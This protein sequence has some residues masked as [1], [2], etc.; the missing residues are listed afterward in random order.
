MRVLQGRGDWRPGFRIES[1]RRY[2]FIGDSSAYGFGVAPDQT[3][4]ASAE[5]QM[6]EL[7]PAWPVE[8]VN[9]GVGGYNLWNSW[10]SFKY[11][12]QVY[13]GVVLAL[14]SNDADLFERSYRVNYPEPQPT[15]WDYTHPFGAAVARCFDDIASFSQASSLPVAVVY[16]GHGHRDPLRIGEIIGDLC[17]S[18]RLLYFDAFAICRDRQFERDDLIVS[19]A[20]S[21][22]SAKVHEGVGRQLAATLR[23]HGWFGESD[24]SEI[25][26]AP[27]RILASAQAMVETD[28]YPA[29]AALN[30]ALVALDAKSRVARRWQASGAEDHFCAAAARASETLNTAS[31]RW[32][33]INRIR[34]LVQ[35]IVIGEYGIA[36][37]L[38]CEHEEK[39]KLEELCFALGTGDWNQLTARLLEVVPTQPLA[40]DS[41]PSD[42]ARFL[43]G[44]SLDLLRFQAAL[45][46]LR[47]LG[48]PAAMGS[49]QDEAFVLADLETLAR[50]ADRALAECTELKASFLRLENIFRGVRSALPEAQIAHISSL[51]GGALNSVKE[52]FAFVPR[53]LAAITHIRDADHASFTTVEVS[54][55][56]KATDERQRWMVTG[57]VNYSVP[58]RLPFRDGGFLPQGSPS[59]V[60]LHFPLFYG[61]RLSLMVFNPRAAI[62][63]Q[64]IDATIVKVELYNGKNQRRAIDPASFYKDANGRFISPLVF[65]L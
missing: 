62:P 36:W 5:R 60:R 26:A 64:A 58:N 52:N 22:P 54:I 46:G 7:L 4:P 61:G 33:T 47:M 55:S 21:H 10:L 40:P 3:L 2:A 23:Q 31:R 57:Q 38:F 17:A 16:F 51:I 35:G 63:P 11:G 65:L 20:D 59:L 8:A 24:A 27:E 50:F 1:L 41:W 37:Y 15:R 13:D 28:H 9:L 45:D 42:A 49:R 44:C 53:L 34:A 25:G 30:W 43:D 19:A 39:L 56:V 18:R 14:C 48:A 12:P 6:N 29:E 32:H